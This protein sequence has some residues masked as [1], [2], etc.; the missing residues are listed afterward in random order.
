MA[1]P[2]GVSFYLFFSLSLVFSAGYPTGSNAEGRTVL[3][4]TFALETLPI[5]A[6][7]TLPGPATTL[8]SLSSRVTLSSTDS[9]QTLSFTSVAAG[10]GSPQPLRLSIF[11]R[12]QDRVRYVELR[13]GTPFLYSFKSLATISV[14]PE[15]K[16]GISVATGAV[17]KLQ[18]ESDKPLTIAR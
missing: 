16:R 11:D 13:P 15:V 6:D 1:S 17:L 9:P 5:G 8:V 4:S 3:G 12:N 14:I 7:V 10:G 18:V 2:A